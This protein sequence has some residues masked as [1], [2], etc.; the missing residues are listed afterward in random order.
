M[1]IIHNLE[2]FSAG[3]PLTT[4][5]KPCTRHFI[6]YL[7][8]TIVIT[9]WT[10]FR[11]PLNTSTKLASFGP[12]DSTKSSIA[13]ALWLHVPK[14]LQTGCRALSAPEGISYTCKDVTKTMHTRLPIPEGCLN[15]DM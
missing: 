9:I 10:H 11:I 5:W 3:G 14:D 6:T 4:K 7:L 13:N 15:G 12:R 1:N 8:G 2:C